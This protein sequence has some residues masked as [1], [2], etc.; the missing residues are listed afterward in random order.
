[1]I[2]KNVFSVVLCLLLTTVVRAQHPLD[3]SDDRL[4]YVNDRGGDADIFYVVSTE[5]F[6]W[7]D[8]QGRVQHQADVFD[9]EQRKRMYSEMIGVDR[10][11]GGSMSF[12]SP[13]YRQAT[14]GV[15]ADP[16]LVPSCL[17]KATADVRQAFDY[18][19]RHLNHGR[20]IVLIGYSQGAFAVTDLLKTVPDSVLPR[21]V[22]TYSIGGRVL[23]NEIDS[24][25]QRIRLARHADDTG[26]VV[27]FNSIQSADRIIQQVSGGNVACINPVNWRT[28]NTPATIDS[29]TIRVDTVTHHLLVEGFDGRQ[30]NYVTPLFG[31]TGN[32]HSMEV[33]F[34]SRALKENIATRVSA[35]LRQQEDG[36]GLPWPQRL[37]QRLD[38]LMADRLLQTSQA[39]VMV[40]DLT[41]DSVLYARHEQQTMR[42]A[43]TMKLLTAV[44]ALD[45][46]G[47]NYQFRTRL[48]YSGQLAGR[49]LTGNVVCTG[50]MDPAFNSDDLNAFVESLRRLGVDTICGRLVADKSMK[51]T[52]K[53]G[54]GWCWDDKNPILSPLLLNRQDNFVERFAEKLRDRGVVIIDT[55]PAPTD[56]EPIL[57]NVCSRSHTMDQILVRM[58]KESDNLYAESMFY[59]LATVSGR[60]NVSARSA[61]NNVIRLVEQLG[62][63]NNSYRI[64]DGSG[65]SLYNYVSAE[66]EVA[67][68]RHAYQNSEV[69]AH[70]HPAL[71]IA[72]EDGTLKKRMA[73][74]PAAGNVHAKTGTLEGVITLAGYC[75]AANG[76]RLCFAILNQGALRSALARNWQDR[77]CV[78]LCE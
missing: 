54:E 10:R 59:Q 42:P 1:M 6:D 17:E 73:G 43:S 37:Q 39:A 65:L 33:R 30:F 40:Y 71:P 18:Y 48:G 72:G 38:H 16:K 7:T 75:T 29:L 41:V 12:Y 74:T 2:L 13:Y 62:M 31:K 26:V 28:D 36:D 52:L 4:W 22:A 20:P 53:W 24:F 68:L 61:R 64:A 66:M 32:Y 76:H 5:T 47:S 50:G 57:V 49:T 35:W 78:A 44:T 45:Q 11:M 21:I 67:F 14:L 15:W 23:Q 58:M 51:D 25:P 9:E 60:K 56:Q 55:V 34:Y 70:L 27:C 46:L 8:A 19:L 69:F 3:Y 77:V 63:G